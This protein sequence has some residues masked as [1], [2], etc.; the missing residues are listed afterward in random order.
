M[1]SKFQKAN[2]KLS[3]ENLRLK[4]QNENLQTRYDMAIGKFRET[5]KNVS[6]ILLK[7][8]LELPEKCGVKKQLEVDDEHHML[9]SI[10]DLLDCLDFAMEM[11]QDIR[12]SLAAELSDA[13]VELIESRRRL[14]L[15]TSSLERC[16]VMAENGKHIYKKATAKR[17]RAS[18]FR[19]KNQ[20]QKLEEQL[21][22]LGKQL[23]NQRK[24]N[25]ALRNN[26][27]PR[28]PALPIVPVDIQENDRAGRSK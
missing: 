25:E 12:E 26:Q 1:S 3:S 10:Q 20:V 14:R 21:G 6:F 24:A 19:W 28:V 7:S 18:A 15:I 27:K 13:H 4:E 16:E 8:G 23:E 2:D 5:I 22:N 11:S 17:W 9:E